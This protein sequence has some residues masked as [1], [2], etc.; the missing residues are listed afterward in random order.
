LFG[1]SDGLRDGAYKRH[2]KF[3]T[4]DSHLQTMI[5]LGYFS[6]EMEFLMKSQKTP[7]SSLAMLAIVATTSSL[8]FGAA[9][10]QDQVQAQVQIYG[11]Q[12][13]TTAERTEYLS[14]MR[15][16]K[17]DKERDVF[18]LDHHETMK[19]RAAEKGVTL[20]DMPQGA[21]SKANSGFGGGHGAGSGQGGST[22]S[23]SG[24]GRG[25]R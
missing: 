3:A 12:L 16:L 13:M 2:L 15:T 20:P 11:S 6:L 4:W 14:K 1:Y 7:V 22:N 17:T 5:F 8:W 25:G 23:P 19:V 18:R 21:G 24:G 10:A 9:Q